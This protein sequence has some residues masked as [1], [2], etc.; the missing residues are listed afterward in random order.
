MHI[1]TTS[2]FSNEITYDQFTGSTSQ[3]NVSTNYST[4]QKLHEDYLKIITSTPVGHI[5]LYSTTRLGGQHRKP[6]VGEG[7]IP[8]PI[9][10]PLSVSKMIKKLDVED[11]E[12]TKGKKQDT[13][14]LFLLSAET[15]SNLT[16]NLITA[17]IS[18]IT[19]TTT[20]LV[21]IAVTTPISNAEVDASGQ[22]REKVNIAIILRILIP[23]LQNFYDR[24][25]IHSLDID[26]D[27]H[28]FLTS[29]LNGLDS[30]VADVSK[31]GDT[32]KPDSEN[33]GTGGI[34]KNITE[35]NFKNGE[36]KPNVISAG[37]KTNPRFA[38]EE[39]SVDDEKCNDDDLLKLLIDTMWRNMR[40]KHADINIQVDDS[41]GSKRSIVASL[42]E[43]GDLEVSIMCSEMKMAF[44]IIARKYCQLQAGSITC[45]AFII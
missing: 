36:F 30:I 20:P 37:Y 8:L 19:E 35:P 27:V 42:G 41:V 7:F 1:K 16:E 31:P 13:E 32:S 18:E 26:I 3:L 17:M 28:R 29:N 4:Q 39:V 34:N 10:I 22:Y 40:E 9:S 21:E 43:N 14:S 45:L 25:Y 33:I 15:S 38:P 2:L 44:R 24:M 11:S 5:Q 23:Y 12:S 6:L